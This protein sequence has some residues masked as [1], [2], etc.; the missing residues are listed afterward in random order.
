M[1]HAFRRRAGE[2]REDHTNRLVEVI[3]AAMLETLAIVQ[4]MEIQMTTQGDQL[5]ALVTSL[6]TNFGLLDQEIQNLASIGSTD[7]SIAASI[8][9]LTTLSA[10][11][12][13]DVAKLAPPAGNTP[14]AD[15]GSTGGTTA[16]QTA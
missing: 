12:Q 16:G 3:A 10:G 5:A 4:R 6:T 9:S 15:A 2:G 8:A 7:P 11:I 14:P 1:N 13:A